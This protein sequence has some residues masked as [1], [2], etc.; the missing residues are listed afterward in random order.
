MLPS[1]RFLFRL[2]VWIGR[3]FGWDRRSDLVTKSTFVSRVSAADYEDS[4]IEPGTVKKSFRVVYSSANKH[5]AELEKNT[6]HA[7]LAVA[8]IER[9]LS[10]R[11]YLGVFVRSV[12][13]LTPYYMAVVA[14]FR[15]RIIYPSLLRDLRER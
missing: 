7:V 13:Q 12:S 10:Y 5:L 14:P 15:H 6:L 3:A 9:E 8:L 2:L 4:L 1:A 11:L